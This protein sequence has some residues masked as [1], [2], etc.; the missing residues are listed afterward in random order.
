LIQNNRQQYFESPTHWAKKLIIFNIYDQIVKRNGGRFLYR[1][2]RGSD[3][4]KTGRE[5][6]WTVLS[7]DLSRRKIAHAIQYRQ[8]RTV[9]S[10]DKAKRNLKANKKVSPSNSCLMEPPVVIE[11]QV[12]CSEQVKLPF[13]EFISKSPSPKA[14]N[15]GTNAIVT[16]HT[17]QLMKLLPQVSA[18]KRNYM[19]SK[20]Q[21]ISENERQIHSDY[22]NLSKRMGPTALQRYLSLEQHTMAEATN[23][24]LPYISDADLDN[25]DIYCDY[26]YRYHCRQR[27]NIGDVKYRPNSYFTAQAHT[28]DAVD[29]YS[30]DDGFSTERM[31]PRYP[32][33]MSV[34]QRD[35]TKDLVSP[36]NYQKFID[37]LD[38][39]T[40]QSKTNW[41]NERLDHIVDTDT[42]KGRHHHD[43][44]RCFSDH[45]PTLSPLMIMNDDLCPS[46]ESILQKRLYS[47]RTT[48]AAIDQGYHSLIPLTPTTPQK[49]HQPISISDLYERSPELFLHDDW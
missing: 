44:C 16:P 28:S 35:R 14:L 23:H 39:N 17:P 10:N 3:N 31:T 27:M 1:E 37:V 29:C 32:S 48:D 13:Y 12:Y 4:D 25:Y 7:K 47:P 15:L 22:L 24:H 45:E 42:R 18:P 33:K 43:Q 36:A 9:T 2:S 11:K 26:E 49:E 41:M 40:N 5:Y 20:S 38:S 19:P 46:P 6:V 8:R 30:F 21:S 34:Y